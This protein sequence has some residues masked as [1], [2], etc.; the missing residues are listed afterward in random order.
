M[1][2]SYKLVAFILSLTLMLSVCGCSKDKKTDTK[3][4]TSSSSSTTSADDSGDANNNQENE[5]SQPQDSLEDDSQEEP[6]VPNIN[7]DDFNWNDGPADDG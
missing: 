6:F 4:K 3:D 1:N 5:E 2:I 7:L